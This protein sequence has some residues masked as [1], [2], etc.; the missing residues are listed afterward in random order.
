MVRDIEQYLLKVC[1]PLQDQAVL[2]NILTGEVVTN[3]KVDKLICCMQGRV[4]KLIPDLSIIDLKNS[5]YQY[6]QPLAK[7]IC[8][9][10]D[11]LESSIQSRCQ[12]WD[13]QS[14]YVYRVCKSPRLLCWWATPVW[15]H[16]LCIL[17]DGWK[18]LPEEEHQITA[19][20]RAA[21]IVSTNRQERARDPTTNPCY[22]HW[23]HG[24]GKKSPFKE[25]WSS[26]QNIPW[27]CYCLD[28]NDNQSRAQ[29]WWNP[30]CF[31]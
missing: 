2:K 17:F 24:L 1:N 4:M 9:P 5:R 25:A 30:Y 26:C 11:H 29:Q 21:E 14:S 3:V 16:Q 28:I 22:C 31:R 6:T 27:L 10:K 13:Y 7:S 8:S 18:W 23:L 12:K 15:D 19:R 20:N